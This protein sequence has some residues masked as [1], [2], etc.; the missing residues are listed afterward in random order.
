MKI[1]LLKN[2]EKLGKK[3]EIKEVASGFA[4]NYL[5]PRGLAKIADKENLEWAKTK[6]EE[7]IKKAE[8]EL[9]K[10]GK[11]VSQIDGLEVE[12]KMKLGEKDQFFEKVTPQK[13]SRRLKE[14][15][16]NID[17]SKIEISQSIE[18]LGEFPVKIKFDHNLEPEITIVI[19]EEK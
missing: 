17:K 19:S 3:Y 15:G 11:L 8:Q 5:I 10:A 13:I 18:E 6:Q 4:R 9:G 16:Y 2:L 14:A 12:I 1:I 7:E